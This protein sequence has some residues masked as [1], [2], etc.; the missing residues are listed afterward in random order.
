MTMLAAAYTLTRI[1][2]ELLGPVQGWMTD[3]YGPRII[4]SIGSPDAW[5]WIILSNTSQDTSFLF[6][7]S[8]NNFSWN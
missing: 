1:E 4:V 5:Y 6:S 7:N 3:R 2:S 8:H